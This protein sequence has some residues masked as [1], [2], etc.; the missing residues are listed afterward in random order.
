MFYR[1][2]GRVPVGLL[3]LLTLIPACQDEVVEERLDGTGMLAIVG[4]TVFTSPAVD[5]IENGVVIIVDGVVEAVGP[6]GMVPVPPAAAVFD[7]TGHSV[8]AGFWNAHVRMDPEILEVAAAGSAAELQQLLQ[9]RFSRFGFTTLVETSTP[10]GELDVLIE[11]I[12]SGEVLGPRIVAVGGAQVFG[13]HFPD[14]VEIPWSPSLLEHLRSED[15][16]LVSGLG[17]LIEESA[18]D[19][20]GG[21]ARVD[22][23]LERLDGFVGSGGRLLFGNGAGYASQ[24]DPLSELLLLADAGIPFAHRLASLTTVPANRFGFAYLGGVEP[25]LVADLVLLEG[26]PEVDVT[27]FGRV[28][29]VL[30][31]GRPLFW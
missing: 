6:R 16:A 7:G 4:A 9:E 14:A 13:V 22:L 3:A 29:L 25:G 19:P 31:E 11:R 18:L 21:A 27:A 2:R 15:V 30:R 8:V 20:V 24:Y 10:R 17:L 23:A 28:R 26:D 12:Q 5:P 1:P